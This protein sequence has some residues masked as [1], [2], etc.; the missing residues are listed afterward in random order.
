MKFT[1]KRIE[2]NVNV[3]K[4]SP[5]K[6]FVILIG[7]LLGIGITLFIALG[8][9]VDLIVP[10]I[11]VDFENKLG[12]LL[13]SK[14][15]NAHRTTESKK[16]DTLFHQLVNHLPDTKHSFS[17]TVSKKD[18]VNA[19][20]LPGGRVVMYKGLID[21]IDS[22]NGLSFVMAHELGHFMHR[23]HLRGMGRALI[24]AVIAT[25][26]FGGDNPLSQLLMESLT[27]SEMTF[28]QDQESAADLFALSLLAK[29]YGHVGGATDFF[30]SLKEKGALQKFKYFFSTHPNPEAR[31]SAIEK[32]IKEKAYALDTVIPLESV[33][34]KD[35]T[36]PSIE[37]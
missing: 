7:G 30:I 4:T 21:K 8:L 10:R 22:E 12:S 25:T 23:D 19:F 24:L 34:V 18:V 16:L 32:E 29:Q 15:E 33:F 5:I 13:Y 17:L 14:F 6:E 1:P 28:S 26:I 31:I 11:S 3:S 9:L 20:A 37:L 27:I 2:G 36:T 35:S